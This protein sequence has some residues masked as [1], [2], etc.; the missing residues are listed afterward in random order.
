MRPL[1]RRLVLGAALACAFFA[2]RKEAVADGQP[3]AE[4]LVIHGTTCDKP[5]VDPAV[6]EVPPLR[7]NC[8]KLLDKKQLPLNQ[9]APS[10]MALPNGRTF[11]VTY[12][13]LTTDKPPRYKVGAFINKPDGPG[14]MPLAEIS[15]EPGKKFHVGGFAY[16]GGALLLAIRILP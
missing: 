8:Y 4:V 10:T 16:Q 2:P 7:Y 12:G 5:S 15:A 13:G 1:G 14:F 9:G 6:G 3:K 11:Q